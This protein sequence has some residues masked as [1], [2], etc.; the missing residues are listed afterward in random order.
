[1]MGN[2]L[3]VIGSR[4]KLLNKKIVV[5]VI[6][7]LALLLLVPVAKSQ[8]VMVELSLEQLVKEANLIVVGTVE[9]VRS[10]LVEGKIFS[11]ATILVSETIK[12]GLEQG[13]NKIVVRFAGGNVGDIGMRVDNG[14]DYKVGE[15]VVAFLKRAP[16]QSHYATVGSFQGK[17]LVKDNVIVRENLSLDEF[18]GKVKK[19]MESNN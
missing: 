2:W 6:S 18:I 9:S 4:R 15:N 3:W 1:M 16:G 11:F 14:P 10:E 7:S 17:F 19:I 5:L 8:A 12:G 13:E